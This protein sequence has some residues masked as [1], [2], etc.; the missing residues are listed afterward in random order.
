MMCFDDRYQHQGIGTE[1]LE[2]EKRLFRSWGAEEVQLTAG[3]EAK[4]RFTWLR[5]GYKIPEET[6]GTLAFLYDELSVSQG[7]AAA[8]AFNEDWQR[9]PT[10][11]RQYV[12]KR[13]D[14][15]LYMEL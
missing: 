8:G 9:W 6:M 7:W 15:H 11:F 2:R 10:E 4:A 14:L 3:C 13:V 12:G 1:I 5:L